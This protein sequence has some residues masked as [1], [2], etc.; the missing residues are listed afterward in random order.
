MEKWIRWEPIPNLSGNFIINSFCMS[1]KTQILLSAEHHDIKLE[2]VFNHNVDAYRYINESWG[3]SVFEDLAEKY[4]GNF[5]KDW[6]FF[7]IQNSNYIKSLSDSSI[8]VSDSFSFI[9]FCIMSSEE[10]IHIL[11]RYEPTVKIL[12]AK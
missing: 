3:F 1:E 10:I 8:G 4:G 12:A 5:Y 6:S 7:K 11:A 9:H 2:I